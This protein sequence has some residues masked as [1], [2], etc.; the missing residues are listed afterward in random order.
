M[1]WASLRVTTRKEDMAYCLMGIFGVNMPL[2]YGEGTR[3]FTRL[4]EIILQET[5]DH[6]IF[7]WHST[8]E[9]STQETTFDKHILS[10]LLALRPSSF[11]CLNNSAPAGFRDD[12][13]AADPAHEPRDPDIHVPRARRRAWQ[14][15]YAG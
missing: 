8:Y 5:G 13:P 6:S 1:H 3:A 2:L 9:T 7:A 14:G 11:R 15:Q 4:Q 10:G 12:G